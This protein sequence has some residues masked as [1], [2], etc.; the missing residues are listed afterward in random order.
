[1]NTLIGIPQPIGKTQRHFDGITKG[2]TELQEQCESIAG[3][4]WILQR[5]YRYSLKSQEH[6]NNNNNDNRFL[7]PPTF[8]IQVIF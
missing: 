5:Y 7:L 4:G 6:F 8:C 1:M 3:I 2:I